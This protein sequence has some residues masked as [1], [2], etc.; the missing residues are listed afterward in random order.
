MC[1]VASPGYKKCIENFIDK[2]DGKMPL[3]R[4]LGLYY[5]EPQMCHYFNWCPPT[6]NNGKGKNFVLI[7]EL[8][9]DIYSH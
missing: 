2:P 8:P 3:I 9:G 4:H 7:L 5:K 6:Q 1:C